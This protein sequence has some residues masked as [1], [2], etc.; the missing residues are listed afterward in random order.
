MLSENVV[1]VGFNHGLGS[2]K[3]KTSIIQWKEMAG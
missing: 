1:N 2:G 3:M